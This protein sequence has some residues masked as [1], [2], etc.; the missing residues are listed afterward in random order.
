ME[1]F[2]SRRPVAIEREIRRVQVLARLKR[3]GAEE[4]YVL[5]AHSFFS[6]G[7]LRALSKL[8]SS[9]IR[10]ILVLYV[11]KTQQKTRGI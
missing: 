1:D 5:W 8:F 10:I 3:T 2:G 7:L 6:L 11:Q 4:Q 9:R